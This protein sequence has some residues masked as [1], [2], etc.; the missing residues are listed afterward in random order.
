MIDLISTSIS[1]LSLAVSG[2]TLYHGRRKPVK[3]V[4]RARLAVPKERAKLLTREERR[5]QIA[6]QAS[7]PAYVDSLDKLRKNLRDNSGLISPDTGAY[8]W[9]AVSVTTA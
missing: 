9:S 8:C 4:E 3:V 6:A 2:Y 1:V 7:D 5:E